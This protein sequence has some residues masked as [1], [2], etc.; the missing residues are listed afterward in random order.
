M[1]MRR[2]NMLTQQNIY[3]LGRAWGSFS[4]NEVD[5]GIHIVLPTTDAGGTQHNEAFA[6]LI[7]MFD[8][9]LALD[10]KAEAYM[11]AIERF[12]ID[13]GV[14][15]EPLWIEAYKEALGARYK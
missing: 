10:A 3:D 12:A 11:G 15:V 7:D 9:L 4:M 8:D 2:L 5:Q 1:M 14:G 6:P 13:R